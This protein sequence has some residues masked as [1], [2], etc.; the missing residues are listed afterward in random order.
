MIGG[1]N[2]IVLWAGLTAAG[3]YQL[4]VTVPAGLPIGDVSVVASIGAVQTLGAV[5]IP[6][7]Q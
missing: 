7:Q 4:N 2:A 1:T 3:L 6:I 5:V